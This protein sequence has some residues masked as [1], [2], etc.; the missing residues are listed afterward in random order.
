MNYNKQS[1]LKMVCSL[2]GEFGHNIRTCPRI[3]RIVPDP[4]D[5]IIEPEPPA[6]LQLAPPI[7]PLQLAP[8][9]LERALEPQDLP[10]PIPPLYDPP[11][12]QPIQPIQP[13][14]PRQPIQPIQPR[15]QNNQEPQLLPIQIPQP[16]PEPFN[17]II[18]DHSNDINHKLDINIHN[19]R[20]ENYILYLVSGNSTVWDLDTTENDLHY[21]GI[22]V[23]NSSFDTKR[24]I[25]ARVLVLPYGDNIIDPE[26]HPPTDKKLWTKPFC[27]IDF[28]NN[29]KVNKDIYIDDGNKLSELNKWKFN[30]LKLDYLLKQVIKLGGKHYDNLEPILDLH[31]DIQLD[32]HSEFEKDRSGI[33]SAFTNIT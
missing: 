15:Q 16:L 4:P 19:M 17:N 27:K 25:G 33:P 13:I 2:C 29:H 30:S 21:I 8:Q 31:Q 26:F 11:P 5:E 12:R 24:C 22:I 18:N 3:N 9:D 14:Q 10:D 32:Q 28:C 1:N 23:A 20:N 6:P 7:A